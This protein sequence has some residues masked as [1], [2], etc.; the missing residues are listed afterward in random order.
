MRVRGLP[1]KSV[2]VRAAARA[3]DES[4]GTANRTRRGPSAWVGAASCGA[5]GTRQA[6]RRRWAAHSNTD[7]AAW[8]GERG[9]LATAREGAVG[10]S[11][12]Q[13]GSVRT[14]WWQW[15]GLEGVAGRKE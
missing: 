3:R 13:G 12:E 6:A 7:T 8:G 5:A 4:G 14:S 10:G 1:G 15:E 2:R 9:T 11:A